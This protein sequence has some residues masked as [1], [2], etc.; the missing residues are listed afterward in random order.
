MKRHMKCLLL[1]LLPCM[2]A[3]TVEDIFNQDIVIGDSEI[4]EIEAIATGFDISDLNTRTTI[5]MGSNSINPVWAVNDTIGIYPTEGDQLSFPIVDGVG[6]SKCVFNGGGWALKTSTA[7]TAYSPFNRNY[8]YK[9][10]NEL[11][12]SM[13]GQKQVGNNNSSHL[14]AYDIQIAKGTTP[15]SGKISFTFAH[16]VAIVRL[17]L[18]APRE[19]EW[20]AIVLE[21][22][23][24][25]TTEAK[26]NL[27]IA[28]PTLT[29]VKTSNSIRLDLENV[30][31]TSSNMD[32]TAYMMMLPI[33]LTDKNLVIK[34]IDNEGIE[35]V[36]TATITNSNH[37][38]AASSARW[39]TADNFKMEG[40]EVHVAT[41]GKLSSLISAEDKYNITTLTLTGNINSD[42]IAFI[43]AMAGFSNSGA[44]TDGKLVR[45][46]LSG[47]NIVSGGSGYYSHSA[48]YTYDKTYAPDYQY[49][50]STYTTSDNVLPNCVFAKT[51]LTTVVLPST[52]T[53]ID[54]QAFYGAKLKSVTIPASA[55]GMVNS[56]FGLYGQPFSYSEI[57][58]I[59]VAYNHPTMLSIDGLLY[60]KN[61]MQLLA[62]PGGRKDVVLPN[63]VTSIGSAAFMGTLYLTNVNISSGVS[64][65]GTSKIFYL[66]SITSAII[67]D[68]TTEIPQDMFY[69]CYNL[70][71]AS[72]PEGV[73][74]IHSGN[75]SYSVLESVTL[76]STIIEI[77]GDAFSHMS[78]LKEVHCKAV[79]P[80]S[81]YNS[82]FYN[83]QSNCVLYVPIGSLNAYNNADVWK[84]FA[85]IREE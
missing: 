15:S 56:Y 68:G 51:N 38:F 77:D 37:N 24:F 43:R 26:M 27:A 5:T 23:A 11:P 61:T 33:D 18:T 50:Y 60:D 46:D 16:Q 58:N 4:T 7:Y 22:D 85:D 55:R 35:Y 52:I 6:T 71:S 36:A 74:R 49:A 72:I 8:Y 81:I 69:K 66:S 3:C 2:G 17:D 73:K 30:A 65:S 82:P 13:L 76:P 34:L 21:S 62:C 59:Y 12:V 29:T 31:T 44:K 1:A 41:A 39:I 83:S 84:D 53:A 9:N 10:S 19:A 64:F 78:E 57:E 67:P 47:C 48:Y 70:S 79:T 25:F 75:F 45:L 32:I 63:N 40:V 28:N 20:S 14:G 80:P 54:N 42:D